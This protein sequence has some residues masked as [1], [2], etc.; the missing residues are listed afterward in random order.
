MVYYSRNIDNKLLEWRNDPRHK[1]L[2]IRGA[3][4]VGKS[5]AVRKLGETFKYFVEINLEKQ[6]SLK[7]LFPTD[8]NVKKTCSDLSATVGIPIIPG[9]TLLF[10]DEIQDCVPAIMALRYFKEDYKELHVIAAG[11]LLEFALE[12]IPSFGVGRIRSLYMYPFSFAEFLSA[13]GLD[14]QVEAIRNAGPE[15]P[16]VETLHKKLTDQVRNFILVGGMPEAVSTWI[17]THDYLACSHVHS[18]IMD[19]YQDDFNKYKKRIDPELLR[20]VLRSVASQCGTKFIYNRADEESRSERVKQA[21]HKLTLAGLITPVTHTAADGV[22]L[23]AQEKERSIKYLFLDTGLLLSWQGFPASDILLTTDVDLVNK[24]PIAE[25]LAGL[26]IIKN[27]DCFQRAE[28][29][30]W[31]NESKNG[32]AEV[33]YIDVHNAK[34]LP[35]E[36]KASTK[37]AMQSLYLFMSKKRLHTAVRISMEPFG[38]FDYTDPEP[39]EQDPSPVRHI[40][41]YPLYALGNLKTDKRPDKNED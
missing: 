39:R 21:L 4:Q 41:L 38:S 5:T 25:V 14:L 6:P 26:E 13:Q 27:K 1:P 31:Q 33:D 19:T 8:I 37:G 34:V 36:V 18:D 7:T 17:E 2:L 24:G 30:Y 11:S 28:M 15:N 9:E 35:I 40:E 16:L 12:E 20:K 22:P 32:N 3:R 29:F 23:G 10:I